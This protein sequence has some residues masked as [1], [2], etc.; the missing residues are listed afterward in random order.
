MNSPV[1]PL[2]VQHP[3]TVEEI[4]QTANDFKDGLT[5]ECERMVR[6]NDN[7]GALAAIVGK[8]Y[9]DKFVHQLKLSA[10]SE[11]GRP[12][13]PKKRIRHI[14]IPEMI[15]KPPTR[16]PLAPEEATERRHVQEVVAAA[17]ERRQP[18]HY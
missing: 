2:A 13:E 4:E 8:E 11:L 14:Y 18:K 6:R 10:G 5:R 1:P 7:S 17:G 9:I 15:K 16:V 12:K 3:L